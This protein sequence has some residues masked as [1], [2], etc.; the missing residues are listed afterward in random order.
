MWNEHLQ[1]VIDELV[2][3]IR[4]MPP[5][6][7]NKVVTLVKQKLAS[8]ES[9]K[10][11]CTLTNTLHHWILPP[12]DLQRAPYVPL[13]EQ[14]VEQRVKDTNN[15]DAL[16]PQPL[17]RITNAPPIMT[18]PNP[19]TTRTLRLTKRTHPRVTRNNTLGSV[20]KIT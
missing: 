15:Q 17:M 4:E 5:E 3:T 11:N 14:R 16:P 2:T 9:D 19:T 10:H 7:Q 1:E 13:P 20:P 12:G 8:H 18:A 6:K